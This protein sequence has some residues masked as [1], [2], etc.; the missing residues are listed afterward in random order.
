MNIVIR[1]LF[2]FVGLAFVGSSSAIRNSMNQLPQNTAHGR[3][4]GSD[5]ERF[6]VLNAIGSELQNLQSILRAELS[7]PIRKEKSNQEKFIPVD[8]ALMVN[9]ADEKD[10][11]AQT[12]VRFGKRG[13]T[14]IRFG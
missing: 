6:D 12:F 10:K 7:K 13:Q 1:I 14:F 9:H 5:M 8:D 4:S 11:R 2:V 3:L